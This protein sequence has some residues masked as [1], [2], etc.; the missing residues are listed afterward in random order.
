MTTRFEKL[1]RDT[2]DF[3]AVISSALKIETPSSH[4]Y[5]L[6]HRRFAD[7]PYARLVFF[8]LA[9]AAGDRTAAFPLRM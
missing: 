2:T 4:W 9:D 1:H 3:A 7:V 5:Q 6:F 8:A